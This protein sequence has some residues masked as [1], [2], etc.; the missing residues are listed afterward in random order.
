MNKPRSLD[1]LK[2]HSKNPQTDYLYDF[3]SSQVQ[4]K[5]RKEKIEWKSTH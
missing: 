1:S 5:E 2:S 4:K 3:F